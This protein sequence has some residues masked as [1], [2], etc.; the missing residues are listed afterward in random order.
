MTKK[1]TIRIEIGYEGGYVT[2]AVVDAASAEALEQKLVAG[3]SGVVHIDAEDS[4]IIVAIQKVAY[5][6]R[7]ARDGRLGFGG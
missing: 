1:D 5:L 3:E 2:G 6:R 7:F 4:T